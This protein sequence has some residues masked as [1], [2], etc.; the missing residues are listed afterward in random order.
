MYIAIFQ[1][2]NEP[3]DR[4]I[5]AARGTAP[6][7][8]AT[9]ASQTYQMIERNSLRQTLAGYFVIYLV[10]ESTG[11]ALD[12]WGFAAGKSAA[13]IIGLAAALL[14]QAFLLRERNPKRVLL[15]LGFGRPDMRVLCISGLVSVALLATIP[16]L[17]AAT[18]G[19]FDLLDNWQL[20]ALSI[21]LLN[22]IAEETVYRGYL[23]HRLHRMYTFPKAV[24]LGTLLGLVTPTAIGY[25]MV[26]QVLACYIAALA[27]SQSPACRVAYV[28][29][30]R[31]HRRSMRVDVQL[32]KWCGP[33]PCPSAWVSAFVNHLSKLRIVAYRGHISLRR[34]L[35]FQ[36]ATR[37]LAWTVLIAIIAVFALLLQA[38]AANA[39]VPTRP[40]ALPA[41][42][43]AALSTGHDVRESFLAHICSGPVDATAQP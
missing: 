31:Q 9:P 14:V 1:I 13:A 32:H 25:W 2:I 7:V 22:G 39:L 27:V 29:R 37:M 5:R 43:R 8:V 26:A 34:M 33:D 18:G 41:A 23:F 24:V 4:W 19:T 42:C 30:H 6:K 17:V 36:S 12:G 15:S 16:F 38:V 28:G 11:R 35:S 3:G 40:A 21:L 20:L 10:L